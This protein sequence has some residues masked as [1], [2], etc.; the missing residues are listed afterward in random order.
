MTDVETRRMGVL[1]ICG[2]VVLAASAWA[3]GVWS[4][5]G[6]LATVSGPELEAL[7]AEVTACESNPGNGG[8]LCAT[9]RI[10]LEQSE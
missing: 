9:K 4:R 2:V 6:D 3:Y 5:S 7:R 8:S 10:L 1:M